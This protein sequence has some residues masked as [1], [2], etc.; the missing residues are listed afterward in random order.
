MGES[1][2][3]LSGA[4]SEVLRGSEPEPGDLYRKAGGP[5]GF[6]WVISVAPSG[7]CYVL[8]LDLEGRLTGAGRYA[9][10]YFNRNV[11]RRVGY[12]ELPSVRV[13]WGIPQ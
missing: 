6:W 1:I 3:D 9:A 5:P 8:A 12:A 11:A 4:P 10:S 7:D 2:L 13:T